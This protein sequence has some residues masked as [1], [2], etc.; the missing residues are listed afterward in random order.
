MTIYNSLN[1]ILVA[2][3]INHYPIRRVNQMEQSC[4]SLYHLAEDI[5]VALTK[6]LSESS[7]TFT[8][9]LQV[10]VVKT[11]NDE[12]YI[13]VD[14]EA[15]LEKK[16]PLRAI[17]FDLALVPMYHHGLCVDIAS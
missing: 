4:R 6:D 16:Q 11:F 13:T 2:N 1:I 17:Y 10:T 3:R 8:L 7:Y 5:S 14:D 12:L 15:S 9:P